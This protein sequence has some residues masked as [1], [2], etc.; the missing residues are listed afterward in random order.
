MML[1]SYR[2]L[3]VRASPY[4]WLGPK[5]HVDLNSLENYPSVCSL[6]AELF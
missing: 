5:G 2:I 3:P 4:I 6:F 1:L